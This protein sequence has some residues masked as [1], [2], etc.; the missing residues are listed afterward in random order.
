[1]I[2][3]I[4]QFLR[5]IS[6]MWDVYFNTKENLHVESCDIANNYLAA[7]CSKD[8]RQDQVHV[9]LKAVIELLAK[10]ATMKSLSYFQV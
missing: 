3:F 9:V 2:A 6:H 10:H 1:M 4:D 8:L 7:C 5:C